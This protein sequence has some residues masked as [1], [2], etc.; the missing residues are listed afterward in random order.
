MRIE[1]KWKVVAVSRQEN[2]AGGFTTTVLQLLLLTTD[3]QCHQRL[4]IKTIMVNV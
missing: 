2:P 4:S 3:M 1:N